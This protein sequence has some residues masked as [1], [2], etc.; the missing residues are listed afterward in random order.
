M[1]LKMEEEAKI[2]LSEELAL[3]ETFRKTDYGMKEYK[4][5][6]NR[7]HSEYHV[8]PIYAG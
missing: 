3:E 2:A 5:N 4:C 1:V 8:F 7:A 6:S